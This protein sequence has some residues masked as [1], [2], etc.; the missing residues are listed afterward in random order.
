MSSIKLAQ[1]IPTCKLEEWSKLSDLDF[2][3]AHTVLADSAYAEFFK[4]RPQDRELI[5]DNSY[6]ELGV[7]LEMSD[8]L[9]AANRC[10]ADYIIA[11]DKVGDIKFNVEQFLLA[12]KVLA[13]YRIAVVMT[14]TP[15]HLQDV[16]DRTT[17]YYHY[18]RE[19]FLFAV[20]EADMLCCTFK[21]P[22]RWDWYYASNMAR[23]WKRVHLLGCAELAE[24]ALWRELAS[25]TGR[26]YSIDTGK[27]LKWALRGKQLDR[28]AS[29]RLNAHTT[30]QGLP[31]E[32]SQALLDTKHITPAQEKLFVYNVQVLRGLL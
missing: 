1:E 10:R 9:E 18:E 30:T 28:L 24:L 31:S 2:V 15:S 3:L 20:R 26:Q 4:M 5:L 6:H 17:M 11:P 7:P 13:G 25:F 21:E 12:Q 23:R 22:R 14:G 8:L 16:P 29:V 32:S 19:N 27:A